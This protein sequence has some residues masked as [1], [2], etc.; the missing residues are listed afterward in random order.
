MTPR[1]RWLHLLLLVTALATPAFGQDGYTNFETVPVRPLALSADGNRLFA[2]NTPDARLEIFDVT[3]SGIEHQGS[4]AVGLD[5][6]AVAVRT[7]EE[8]EEE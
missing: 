1:L 3:S 7:P 2:V 6:V 4:V 8:K 5:P